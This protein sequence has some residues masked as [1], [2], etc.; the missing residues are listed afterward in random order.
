MGEEKTAGIKSKGVGVSVRGRPSNSLRRVGKQGVAGN[1]E[2]KPGLKKT[3][4]NRSIHRREITVKWDDKLKGV[5]LGEAGK[6]ET[7]GVR[8]GG[9]VEIKERVRVEKQMEKP[10][11]SNVE[12]NVELNVESNVDPKEESKES[13]MEF[14]MTPP[15]KE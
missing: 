9:N 8:K 15:R 3:A 10:M 6:K 13:K 5:S 11:E 7:T 2:E 14:E 1:V 4:G 12:S